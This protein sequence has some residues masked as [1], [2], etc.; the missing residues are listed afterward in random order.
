MLDARS[1]GL[2]WSHPRLPWSV[3]LATTVAPRAWVS[4]QVE[5]TG[6]GDTKAHDSCR[7]HRGFQR[8][9]IMASNGIQESAGGRVMAAKQG[10]AAI[11]NYTAN[12]NT[13]LNCGKAIEIGR[14]GVYEANHKKFCDCSCAAQHNNRVRP[15]RSVTKSERPRNRTCPQCGKGK[16]PRRVQCAECDGFPRPVMASTKA[17]IFARRK[18]WWSGAAGIRRE[19]CKAYAKANLPQACV[20]CGYSRYTEV[21]H[22][23]PVSDFSDKAL[24]R[25]INAVT[26]LVRL[27]P[28]HHWE[29]DSG[30][31][32]VEDLRRIR[33]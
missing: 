2:P 13:C 29:A 4:Y 5:A 16:S 10:G 25:E 33:F 23:I 17:E 20:I 26:N 8:D 27:C 14:G 21:H 24:I 1:M 32:S 15:R 7:K 6:C 9:G 18:N 30:F 3:V 28:T 11:V 19:A 31:I 12:P 22:V